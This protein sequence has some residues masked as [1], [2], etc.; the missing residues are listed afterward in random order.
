MK[1]KS[2]QGKDV[3]EQGWNSAQTL[4]STLKSGVRDDDKEH[5]TTPPVKSLLRRTALFSRRKNTSLVNRIIWLL[6]IWSVVVYILG[7]AGL[8]WSSNK[9]IA[10]NFSQQATDWVAKLDELGTPLYAAND[11]FLFQSIEEQVSR[12]PEVSYLRYYEADKNSIIASYATTKIRGV[13]IPELSSA[14]I[15]KLRLNID[16]SQPVFIQSADD[17]LS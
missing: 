3:L 8:W 2:E 16:T 1:T 4:R 15:E 5:V 6:L 12:F 7:V 9:V 11:E 13:K 10:D 17:S 14:I